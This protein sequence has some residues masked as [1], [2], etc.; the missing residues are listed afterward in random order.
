M[1]PSTALGGVSK[2]LRNMLLA[3][4]AQPV[5]VTLLRPDET[6]VDQRVNLFLHRVDEHPQ[7]RNA[8]YQLKPGS[9][10]TLAAPP[11]SLVL[12]YLLTAY[13]PP[14]PETGH[15]DA[16]AILGEAM[17]VFHQL[18]EVPPAHLDET[19]A[20]ASERL[21]IVPLPLG[22]DEIGHLWST[23]KEPYRLSAQYEVSV[24]QLDATAAAQRTLAPRVRTVGVPEIRAPFE[25]PRILDLQPR[26]GQAG[27]VLTITGENLAGWQATVAVSGVE[28]AAGVELTGDS[29]QVSLPAGLPPGFHKLRV[30]VSRLCRASYFVEVT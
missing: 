2:S 6:G 7:L 12:R 24:V 14:Q 23:L 25:P 5:P 20:D 30:D 27:T 26:S 8:D 22:S 17:R 1:S 29:L 19:L 28:L 4:M 21:C 10:S 16:Q 3:E 11:L 18:P 9:T 13:S 15:A